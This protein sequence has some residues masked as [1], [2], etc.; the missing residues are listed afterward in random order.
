VLIVHESLKFELQDELVDHVMAF[1]DLFGHFLD[2]EEGI[3]LFMDRLVNCAELALAQGL[4]ELEVV[5]G[6]FAVKHF[7]LLGARR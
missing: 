1:D 4:A 7:A 6:N 2:C 5:D 3:G